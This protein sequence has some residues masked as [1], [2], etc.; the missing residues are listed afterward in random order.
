MYK[1]K[2]QGDMQS[3]SIQGLGDACQDFTLECEP[4][5]VMQKVHCKMVKKKTR[6]KFTINSKLNIHSNK[7]TC[8]NYNHCMAFYAVVEIMTDILQALVPCDCN[9]CYITDACFRHNHV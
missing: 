6:G 3:S 2:T 7:S 5:S 4:W 9:L 1:N 8:N